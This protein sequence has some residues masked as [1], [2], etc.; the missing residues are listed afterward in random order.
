MEKFK[1]KPEKPLRR[2]TLD[3]R[4][5]E[6]MLCILIRNR[7][8]FEAVREVMSAEHITDL[9]P[10]C[11]LLWKVVL[12]FFD[13]YGELPP[14]E[15][16][17]DG[18]RNKLNENPDFL[19]ETEMSELETFLDTAFE[20][21]DERGKDLTRSK[22]STD[23]GISLAKRFLEEQF[24][25]TLR[26]ETYSNETLPED[27]PALLK[28]YHTSL[29]TVASLGAADSDLVFP[30]GWEKENRV[31]LRT[32]GVDVLDV[33]LG[34]GHTGQE[35]YILMGP[36]GSCK[37]LLALQ[38]IYAETVLAWR[39]VVEK[40]NEGK[41]PKVF[42]FS[43]ETTRSQF[44]RRILAH[45][46]KIPADRIASMKSVKDGLLKPGD[47]RDTY[48]KEEFADDFLAGRPVLSE[49]E[50]ATGAQMLMNDYVVF[51]D[52]TEAN[53]KNM[54][55]GTGG[56]QE[57]ARYLRAYLS[58]ES[59][60]DVVPYAIWIDHLEALVLRLMN[61]E[62]ADPRN[63]HHYIKT[64]VK[65]ASD[66]IA[67]PFDVPTWVLHQLTG[68][69]N[70][71]SP[72]KKMHHTMGSGAK[73]VAEFADFSIQIGQPSQKDRVCIFNCTKH[74]R[75]P[76][77]P[78]LFVQIDGKFQRVRNCNKDYGYDRATG[79]FQS[80]SDMGSVASVEEAKRAAA[81]EEAGA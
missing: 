54:S 65:L 70:A 43:T 14:K 51:V 50:R 17:L 68:E 23:Y 9:G 48:E 13:Q 39:S 41:R 80:R 5:K 15:F 32:T 27:M 35:V 28:R 58:Q 62:S 57:I 36:Y 33:F 59:N 6:T 79:S 22:L 73:G 75:T 7:G 55:A 45:G 12:K 26:E 21:K 19:D 61:N 63:M 20:L 56:M 1:K 18:L 77:F 46:A 16:M 38:A 69:A 30:P 49:M 81:K 34:G 4:Q 74:R 8:A 78:S 25:L 52:M 67:K 11:G 31:K 47:E 42:Y 24:A 2:S 66:L 64:Q 37:T 72:G 40:T 53:A 44:Q 60:K 29:E 76:P 10:G 71:S 3:H